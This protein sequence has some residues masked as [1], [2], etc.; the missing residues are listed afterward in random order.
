MDKTLQTE[1]GGFHALFMGIS[2][3]FLNDNEEKRSGEK[4][5]PCVSSKPAICHDAYDVSSP[6]GKAPAG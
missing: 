6:T 3:A 1:F 5:P 2:E 4:S